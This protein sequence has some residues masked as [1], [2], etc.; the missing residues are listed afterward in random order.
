ECFEPLDHG[1]WCQSISNR[2]YYNS[3]TNTCRNFHYTG[4]GKSRNIFMTQQECVEKCINQVNSLSSVPL[5][6]VNSSE[7]INYQDIESIRKQVLRVDQ[8][9][10][11]DTVSYLKIDDQWLEYGKCIGYRYNITGK[12][13]RL[14]S[15]LCSMKSDGTCHAQ[16]IVYIRD[17]NLNKF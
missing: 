7:Q 4:C 6:D 12:R 3:D 13:T 2:F 11:S 9:L 16:V 10:M 1:R 14:T 15:Y 5:L 17:E 8:I